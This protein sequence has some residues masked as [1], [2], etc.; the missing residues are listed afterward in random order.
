MGAAPLLTVSGRN[1]EYEY[2]TMTAALLFLVGTH[3]WLS[4]LRRASSLPS[5]S[6]TLL[7]LLLSGMTTFLP[8]LLWLSLGEHLCNPQEFGL[9]LGIQLPQAYLGSWALAYLAH[10][11]K[12]P[13]MRGHGIVFGQQLSIILIIFC[14]L[15]F[16]PQKR[17]FFPFLG[18][19]HGPIYDDL[20]LMD[21]G[22]VG[23]SLMFALV[24][25]GILVLASQP[26]GRPRRSSLAAVL[27]LFL[28][29]AWTG[30][31]V[32]D[33]P[34]VG[35]GHG[36]LQ[37]HFRLYGQTTALRFYVQHPLD[38]PTAARHWLQAQIHLQHLAHALGL[39]PR[40]PILIYLYQHERDKK[41]MFGGGETDVTDVVTPSIHISSG[42]S[43][44]LH[45]TLRH[46]LVHALL[47][48]YAPYGLGF[49]PNMALTEGI[50]EA[51]A[52]RARRLSLDQAAA[53]I[54]NSG[55]I[56]KVENLFSPLFWLESGPRAY[57]V[58][59]SFT[60]FLLDQY[61]AQDFLRL[62]SG[63]S[64]Q[65]AYGMNQESLIGSWRSQLDKSY[66]PKIH[67]VLAK[68]LF[69][70]PGV[71]Q[72][73][74]PH[75]RA[76]NAS[77]STEDP[78]LPHRR[79]DPWGGRADFL[80]WATKVYPDHQGYAYEILLQAIRNSIEDH[81]TLT[82]IL[83]SEKPEIEKSSDSPDK[84]NTKLWDL[85]RTI[86]LSDLACYLERTS[87]V[88]LLNSHLSQLS[89]RHLLPLPLRTDIYFRRSSKLSP[90]NCKNLL[91]GKI[92]TENDSTWYLLRRYLREKQPLNDTP[93]LIQAAMV[94]A[95]KQEFDQ[96]SF[97]GFAELY[98]QS[99]LDQEQFGEAL[100]LLEMLD[101]FFS[102]P[103][104]MQDV[105]EV[106]REYA[107]QG[108]RQKGGIAPK[109]KSLHFP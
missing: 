95:Q 24:F 94:L 103:N 81:A 22:I 50:A 87:D 20:I 68:E 25:V 51:L 66:Q 47:S 53:H 42:P 91:L 109:G 3:L 62:F 45:S 61:P 89:E 80:A 38:D 37:K 70:D 99:L 14:V 75:S 9:W 18:F 67:D 102:G 36:A 86:L 32:S 72:D 28:A 96:D 16:N 33:T 84:K 29:A 43:G 17:G 79:Q 59:A 98:I 107:K 41:L 10:I 65:D 58:A 83:S 97:L 26:R 69:A 101:K 78:W 74:C 63:A 5:S 92:E 90:Q 104:S 73:R 71:F 30:G 39:S 49:H 40:R 100:G 13:P 60:K 15:W 46:E 82:Q 6:K 7:L 48:F 108:L 34:S 54:L 106:Y 88:S 27:A 44:R 4:I 2:A 21:V 77:T 56:M 1:L 105:F 23:M 76:I 11:S 8:A 19:L 31:K 12:R 52:P 93:D 55:K 85:Y 64:F 35:F 57:S